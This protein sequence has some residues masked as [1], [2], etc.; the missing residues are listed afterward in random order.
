MPTLTVTWQ[1][2]PD[3]QRCKVCEELQGYRWIFEGED[4]PPVLQHPKFGIV[5]NLELNTSH[6]HEFGV[7]SGINCRCSL[8]IDID[9]DLEKEGIDELVT[10]AE[11][12]ALLR[13]LKQ[14]IAD[15]KMDYHTVR[16]METLLNRTLTILEQSTGSK[17]IRQAINNIQRLITIL[18]MAQY[19]IHAFQVATGPIGWAMAISGLALTTV[20]VGATFNPANEVHGR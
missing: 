3:Q 12:R 15:L 16:E 4:L 6:A 8:D 5:W 13:Q 18:R 20:T 14:E 11:A 10:V 2:I 9:V 17:E 7:F 1:S 19:S